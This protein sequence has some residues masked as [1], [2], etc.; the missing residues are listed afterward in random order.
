[1]TKQPPSR[2]LRSLGAGL[3]S[4]V[5]VGSAVA[6][7]CHPD[8]PGT[9]SLTV[10]GHIEAYSMHGSRVAITFRARGCERVMSWNPLAL[11]ASRSH[12]RGATGGASRSNRP[13]AVIESATTVAIYR[14]SRRVRLYR[15]TAVGQPK[16]AVLHGRS[17][18]VLTAGDVLAD[19]PDR[20]TLYDAR[21]GRLVHNW[22]LAAPADTLDVARGV[23][24][25][26]T[27]NGV[28]AVRLRDGSS[29]LV[30]VKYRGDS[31]QIERPGIVYHDDLGKTHRASPS[32]LKFVPF[33]L[34]GR[35]LRPAGPLHIPTTVGDFSLDGR[36]AI[37]VTRGA[38]GRCDRIGMWSIPWHFT[39]TLMSEP[40]FC[41][42]R[43]G[44][45]GITSLALGGQYFE[46][47]TTY[48][49]VQ[50]LISSTIVRCVERVIARSRLGNGGAPVRSIAADGPTMAYGFGSDGRTADTARVGFVSGLAAPTVTSSDSAPLQV[51]VFGDRVAVLRA[52]GLVDLFAERELVDT[53]RPAGARAIALR[54][55]ELVALTRRHTIDVVSLADGTRVHSWRIPRGASRALD[56][57]FGVA[58]FTVG[59]T[60][61]ALRLTTGRTRRLLTTPAA[62]AAQI[63]DV[64]VVY[65]YN[66]RG[67]GY[68]GFV[69]FAAVERKLG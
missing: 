49:G 13:V 31:P 11:R 6:Y 53:F 3:L 10:A 58:V 7:V 48:H 40:P 30:G 65:R 43:G 57:H 16:Q 21:S 68:L 27:P 66:V 54:G 32:V 61:F 20:L 12:C 38:H 67:E 44:S 56:V 62:V 39:I 23:A 35:E 17:L 26:A 4:L 55:A 52:D 50:T 18:V 24:V 59:R 1:V 2:L 47:V 29:A 42:E 51:S 19:R 33:S 14:G 8:R 22:P 5:F 9:R 45:G 36:T 46:A 37:F 64:G 28:Y 41:P 25:L 63:D 15:L 34:V 69:P 60:V